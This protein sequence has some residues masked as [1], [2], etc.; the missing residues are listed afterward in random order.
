MTYEKFAQTFPK[1]TE[2]LRT[3]MSNGNTAGYMIIDAESDIS[4][5]DRD[6]L[7]TEGFQAVRNMITYFNVKD[8]DNELLVEI[9]CSLDK[10]ISKLCK[11]KEYYLV[12]SIEAVR[13]IPLC[14]ATISTSD[15]TCTIVVLFAT[16]FNVKNS[17]FYDIFMSTLLLADMD[18]REDN[19]P[20]EMFPGLTKNIA[21]FIANDTFM[22]ALAK[23]KELIPEIKVGDE[24]SGDYVDLDTEGFVIIDFKNNTFDEILE[25]VRQA[26]VYGYDYIKIP[27][28]DYIIDVEEELD[29]DL[30]VAAYL[31]AIALFNEDI[32]PHFAIPCDS[33]NFIN[34]IN[35]SH[36]GGPEEAA[37]ILEA[38]LALPREDVSIDY[39]D[40]E[41]YFEDDED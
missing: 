30:K 25:A 10:L 28:Y 22:N 33:Y 32:P 7:R 4:W 41:D 1:T 15:P 13:N 17:V 16:E 3:R 24:N 19:V 20:I 5:L 26:D 21:T 14:M 27:G 29:T 35:A 12:N 31:Y 11:G 34:I 38:A 6:E 8:P 36:P 18:D 39:D 37:I 9:S 2:V 23:Y 40:D